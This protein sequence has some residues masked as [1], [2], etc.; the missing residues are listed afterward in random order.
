MKKFGIIMLLLSTLI[1]QGCAYEAGYLLGS[2]TRYA[3]V[4]AAVQAL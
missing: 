1:L 4:G 2:A 3:G